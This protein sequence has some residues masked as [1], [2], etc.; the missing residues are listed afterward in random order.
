MAARLGRASCSS[1]S[2]TTAELAALYASGPTPTRRTRSPLHRARR[3][4]RPRARPAPLLVSAL[5]GSAT[6]RATASVTSR[7]P[8]G[9]ARSRWTND[10]QQL[11]RPELCEPDGVP[12]ERLPPRRATSRCSARRWPTAKSMTSRLSATARAAITRRRCS[13]SGVGRSARVRAR[14]AGHPG[15]ADQPAHLAHDRRARDGAARRSRRGRRTSPKRAPSDSAW[16]TAVHRVGAARLRRG[17]LAARRRR[18]R[19]RRV[20]PGARAGHRPRI[21]RNRRV[22]AWQCRLD[23]SRRPIPSGPYGVQV[24]GPPRR[25]ARAWDA[26]GMGYHARARARRFRRRSRPA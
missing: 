2:A 19:P 13:T 17:G 15:L 11:S 22:V 5:N 23:V 10:L 12:R 3:Q 20:R 4:D 14:G 6:S 18:R 9:S 26:L 21:A 7:R 25:A 8:S 24:A 1:R 16:R